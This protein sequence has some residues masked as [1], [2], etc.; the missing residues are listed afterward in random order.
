[1]LQIIVTSH[2][3]QYKLK[4]VSFHTSQMPHPK[5]LNFTQQSKLK[6][7]PVDYLCVL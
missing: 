4:E 1:M 2:Y 6:V 3:F 5:L 7:T